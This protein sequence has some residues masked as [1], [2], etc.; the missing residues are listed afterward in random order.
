M[1]RICRIENDMSDD[2]ICWSE[3]S[4]QYYEFISY[5]ILKDYKIT[6]EKCLQMLFVLHMRGRQ[7]CY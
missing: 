7:I 1:R 5:C 3:V 4:L 2:F 6:L